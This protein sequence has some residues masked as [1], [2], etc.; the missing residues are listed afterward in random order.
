MVK[1]GAASVT[2][3]VSP[4]RPAIVAEALTD[5]VRREVGRQ[6]QAMAIKDQPLPVDHPDL[7]LRGWGNANAVA[8]RIVQTTVASVGKEST[9]LL[10]AQ[11]AIRRGF[12]LMERVLGG[13]PAVSEETRKLVELKFERLFDQAY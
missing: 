13:L 2:A 9:Q 3:Q 7:V 6:R 12:T 8:D 4:K 5:F 10:A 1:V 11:E